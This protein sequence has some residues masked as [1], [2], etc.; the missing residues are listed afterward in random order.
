MQIIVSDKKTKTLLIVKTTL[1]WW[2]RRLKALEIQTI[3]C[4]KYPAS[5][6]MQNKWHLTFLERFSKKK[7]TSGFIWVDLPYLWN[8]SVDFD[9]WHLFLTV[10]ANRIEGKLLKSILTLPIGEWVMQSQNSQNRKLGC[11]SD[12]S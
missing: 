10:R 4:N 6:L 7:T 3:T 1:E 5:R 8:P 2:D 9:G 12:S 11:S